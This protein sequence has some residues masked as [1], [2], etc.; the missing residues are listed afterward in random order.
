MT[1]HNQSHRA[2]SQSEERSLL[3]QLTLL[4]WGLYDTATEGRVA[5]VILRFPL[6]ESHENGILHFLSFAFFF[7]NPRSFFCMKT[8]FVFHRGLMNL[9]SLN[10]MRMNRQ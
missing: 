9:M 3:A 8:I 4:H 6:L 2:H 7:N 1:Q 10:D 5:P